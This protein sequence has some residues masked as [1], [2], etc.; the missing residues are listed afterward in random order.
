[1]AARGPFYFEAQKGGGGGKAEADP[2][3][4]FMPPAGDDRGNN[5]QC[6]IPKMH[7]PEHTRRI[8][9]WCP[10][11]VLL[12]W[13]WTWYI[14]ACS[15]T[16]FSIRYENAVLP[17]LFILLTFIIVINARAIIYLL[18][19]KLPFFAWINRF[20]Y[21]YAIAGVVIGDYIFWEYM[22]EPV[23]L[24]HRAVYTSVNPS[25]KIIDGLPQP[26]QGKRYQ[27]GGV[28]YFGG[29]HVKVDVSRAMSFKSRDVFCVAPIVDGECKNNC[30]YEFWAVG[31]NCCGET[32]IDFRCGLPSGGIQ[33]GGSKA[34]LRN[35]RAFDRPFYRLAVTQ[36][37]GVHGIQSRHPIFIDYTDHE[38]P[39]LTLARLQQSALR[40]FMT[41]L[42][43]SFGVHML[44]SV[45]IAKMLVHS[46]EPHTN[47]YH[48]PWIN[49]FLQYT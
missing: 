43:V 2:Y 33:S 18:N 45:K 6:T 39:M 15:L 47:S 44:I 1:M 32:Y 14:A 28:F 26:A 27:D 30:A 34:G 46:Y 36:A 42:V 41:N 5:A 9:N 35:V 38:D 29:A 12:L 16:M 17:L 21:I 3:S 49:M 11:L 31:K 8:I 40:M 19:R 25:T 37:E 20:L 22:I 24:Q 10:F 23:S 7:R 48:N 13:P 4:G